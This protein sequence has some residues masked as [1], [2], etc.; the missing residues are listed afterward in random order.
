MSKRKK[1][2]N[3]ITI[4][5][6][7]DEIFVEC[8]RFKV[9]ISPDGELRIYALNSIANG[10]DTEITIKGNLKSLIVKQEHRGF[11]KEIPI[12][13]DYMKNPSQRKI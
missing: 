8:Y 9:E 1:V 10:G 12:F 2:P 7:H 6:E 11:E 13:Q 3:P 4:D 5:E